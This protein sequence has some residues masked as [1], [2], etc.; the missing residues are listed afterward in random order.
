MEFYSR[1][2][3]L[4]T[5]GVMACQV[6]LATALLRDTLNVG[7]SCLQRTLDPRKISAMALNSTHPG[8][9][10]SLILYLG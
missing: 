6:A 8:R 3:L 9:G 10:T 7:P 4:Q 1:L 2:L 5:H